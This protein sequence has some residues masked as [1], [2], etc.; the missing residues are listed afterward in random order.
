MKKEQ[1]TV[2]EETRAAIEL[3][4]FNAFKAAK[5]PLRGFATVRVGN[6]VIKDIQLLEFTKDGEPDFQIAMP[7]AKGKDKDGKDEWY[8][9]VWLDLGSKE[10]NARAYN[11][12]CKEVL[13]VYP[14]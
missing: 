8:P 6:V 10:A 1:N 14:G 12:I 7:Q 2:K 13:A 5:G 4:R 11:D 3:V 9:L